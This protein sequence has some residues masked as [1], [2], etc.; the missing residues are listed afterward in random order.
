MFFVSIKFLVQLSR[1]W[2]NVAQNLT[3]AGSQNHYA[4]SHN[5]SSSLSVSTPARNVATFV[6]RKFQK[7]SLTHI[8]YPNRSTR[9]SPDPNRPTRLIFGNFPR[10]M[11]PGGG[12]YPVMRLDSNLTTALYKSFTYL[13]IKLN[14][15]R[16]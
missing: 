2:P 4:W 5:H 8:P 1:F 12:L 7:L 10:E 15:R 9:R 3:A 11:T 16:R 14:M 6:K 13:M